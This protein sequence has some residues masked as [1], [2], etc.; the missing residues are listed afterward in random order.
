MFN[1]SLCNIWSNCKR[2]AGGAQCIPRKITGKRGGNNIQ[3]LQSLCTSGQG[4]GD[5]WGVDGL[6]QEVEPK[7]MAVSGESP[8]RLSLQKV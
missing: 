6:K 4:V 5:M 8:S 2:K 7:L 1:K 3:G